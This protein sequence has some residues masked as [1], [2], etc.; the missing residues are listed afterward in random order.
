MIERGV[1]LERES[2]RFGAA[3]GHWNRW[4]YHS[5][6]GLG[7]YEYLQF[8][9]DLGAEPLFVVNAGFSHTDSVPEEEIDRW[10]QDAVDAIEYANGPITSPWGARCAAN[11]H[12]E[13]FQLRFLEI[14]NE[15][16]GPL[17]ERNFAR[18]TQAIKAHFPE[19]R[20]ISN[21]PI[22]D[23]P[24]E[25]VDRHFFATPAEMAALATHFDGTERNGTTIYVGEYAACHGY[26]GIG[27]LRAALGEAAFMTGL[28]RN[29]DLVEMASFAPLFVNVR[30]RHWEVDAIGFDTARCY[31]TPSYYVQQLFSVHRC[32]VI[33]PC[34]LRGGA[35]N[36]FAFV[37]GRAA[38]GDI[39]IKAVN[40]ASSPY[41]L[42][43]TL[44]GAR[45]AATGTAITLTGDPDAAN[46]LIHPTAVAPV[47]RQLA[48]VAAEFS[49]TFPAASLTILRINDQV[50]GR[51]VKNLKSVTF[52]AIPKIR[53]CLKC[54][55]GIKR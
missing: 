9:E 6:G 47:C 21:V 12:P 25:I 43:I 36:D 30:D 34:A 45:P 52:S 35:D 8:C 53:F 14:G 10:V 1:S 17:Y 31:G 11:G 41:D 26:C 28:E 55:V 33:L 16:G 38:D 13:S 42:H 37:A 5:S 23:Q 44:E 20:I 2:G 27:N 39:V 49:Y 32:A 15:N 29:G 4:G 48:G 7:F 46:T 18:F 51:D 40:M 54:M 3:A 50:I 22:A 19:V 24:V